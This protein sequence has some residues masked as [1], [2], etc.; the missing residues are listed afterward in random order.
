M[1]NFY[2]AETLMETL[3]GISIPEDVF[4]EL[5]LVAW[6]LIGNK[7]YKLYQYKVCVNDCNTSIEL[8]CNVDII[9]AVTTGWEDWNHVTNSLPD[10]DITSAYTESYI[11]RRKGFKH[12]LYEGG[13][14]IKY[15][16]VGNTLY[17][18]EPYGN[19]N[20]LYK[21]IILDDNGLPELTDKE[22]LAIAT[23]CAYVTKYKEGIATN[24][25][26]IISV[27]NTLKAQW[28]IQ[29][30]QARVTEYLNQNQMDQILDA[31]S[32]WNRKIHNKSYKAIR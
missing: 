3:Y 23:Y 14:Y 27:A 29:C 12:P 25:T 9:E 7:R 24:N 15:E 32:N 21:G 31:K 6:N 17:F 5:A 8:P 2:Y 10:G 1:N 19:I 30:D 28:M 13:K 11:E 16:Q 20:I 4:E 22:A 26:T 18:K